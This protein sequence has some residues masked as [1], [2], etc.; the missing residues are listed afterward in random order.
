MAAE[1]VSLNPRPDDGD[2][3]DGIAPQRHRQ[4][5]VAVY[6]L[7]ALGWVALSQSLFPRWFTRPADLRLASTL[8]GIAL[9]LASAA[10]LY[11]LVQ[12]QLRHELMLTRAR[13]KASARHREAR[14][15][16]EAIVGKSTDAIFA[17][18]L[19][20]RYLL[21]NAQALRVLGRT[22]QEV[23]GHTDEVLYPPEMV[24]HILENDRQVL[25]DQ[26]AIEFEHTVRGPQG[27]HV[28]LAV[29]APLVDGRGAVVGLFGI[30]RDITDRR[31]MDQALRESEARYRTMIEQS[32]DAIVVHRAGRILYANPA[33]LRM[34]GVASAAEALGRRVLDFAPVDSRDDVGRLTR[35]LFTSRNGW[36]VVEVQVCRSDG[37]VIDVALR[38]SAIEFDGA[39]AVQIA[40]RDI[41]GRKRAQRALQASEA[42]LR[43]ALKDKDALLR[44]V[45]HRVKNNLQ[46]IDSLLRMETRRS[47]LEET[48]AVLQDMQG[49][50]RTMAQLHEVLHRSG[51]VSGIDLGAYLG[52]L[53]TRTLQ[54]RS[55]RPGAV[56]VQLDLAPVQ[57]EM[58]QATPC[59]LLVNE[60]VS[61]SMKHGFADGRSGE[62]RVSL[63]QQPGGP[64]L[65][66]Q[67]SDD[68]Q[69]LPQ[70]WMA[71]KKRGLGLQ[72]ADDLAGQLGGQLVM[73][74]GPAAVF[75]LHFHASPP[76][77]LT[78]IPSE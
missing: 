10:L 28:F 45:H 9:V 65:V 1:P 75:T 36:E 24:R 54:A 25:R 77:A 39:P 3:P 41:S 56:R 73:G 49:R 27:L 46:V 48:R 5:L 64:D 7:L 60:L 70:D 58:D 21:M 44:E 61:N 2:A 66:L 8:A 15:L 47:D 40:M 42:Q 31:R 29:K 14:Q 76:R 78:G 6:G 59:G 19:E 30:S 32:P 38:G 52:Q 11:R 17:K 62:V 69:G 50:I 68:G 63:R 13:R 4:R 26:A 34:A 20:G 53:I 22:E 23:I 18:D 12:R 43:V 37:S 57:V 71:R 55:T 74:P 67:V 35:E 72:L 51:A 33:A 16:L